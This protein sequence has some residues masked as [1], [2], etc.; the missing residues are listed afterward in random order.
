LARSAASVVLRNDRLDTV[1]DAIR[2]GRTI[3]KNIEK[4]SEF[5]ISSNLSEILTVFS[6][7]PITGGPPLTS[8]QLPW[9]NLLSD[10]LPAMALAAQPPEG[11][12]M[13]QPLALA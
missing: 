12:V 5:L 3:T 2:Q 4:S 7:L 6:A 11:D 13:K 1:L 9:I 8:M 10:V